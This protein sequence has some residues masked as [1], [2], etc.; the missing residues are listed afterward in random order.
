MKQQFQF[1]GMAALFNN[2]IDLLITPDPLQRPGVTFTPV[3][4][5]QQVLAVAECHPLANQ[6][7]VMPADL[8]DQVL[9]TYPVAIERLDIF[10]DF[11]L[12]AQQMP[13]RHKTLESTDIIVEMV[14][15]NRGVT[16]LPD[17]LVAELSERFAITPLRLGAK[18]IAK[19]LYVGIR[20][21]DR[22]VD[23]IEAFLG[24]VGENKK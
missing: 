3:L 22:E 7:Q 14:A 11:L 15:A 20:D 5:Y 1:G 8:A 21:G 10:S 24:Q 13:K 19:Q 23:Y 6:T 17:W 18:G 16:A 2:D 9:F 4:A 12:P